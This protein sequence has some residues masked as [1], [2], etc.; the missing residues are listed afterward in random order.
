[1]FKRTILAAIGLSMLAAPMA[2]AQQHSHTPKQ[3]HQYS[4]PKKP[5]YQAPKRH[6]AQKPP[7]QRKWAKGHKVQDWKKR[8][9]VRDYHR[10]G[11]KKPS[12]GQEWI[13]VDN[14]YLLITLATGLIAGV[15]AG[16]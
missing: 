2:Q 16:R 6:Q 4:Q 15:A 8:P 3:T 9:P 12:R 14:N 10:Y 11:L 5:A 1:M 13:K 7:M